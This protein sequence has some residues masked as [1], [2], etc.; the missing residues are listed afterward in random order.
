LYIVHQNFTASHH[1]ELLSSSTEFKTGMSIY[2]NFK[3]I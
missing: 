1:G 3:I 2:I